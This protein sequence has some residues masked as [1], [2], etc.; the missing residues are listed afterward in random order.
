LESA[1]RPPGSREK[2]TI[3]VGTDADATISNPNTI[4]DKATFGKGLMTTPA[5]SQE[6]IARGRLGGKPT[7]CK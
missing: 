6:A 2:G 4:I 7:R 1:G 3:A 5:E